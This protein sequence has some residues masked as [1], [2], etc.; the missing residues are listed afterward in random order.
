MLHT[1]SFRALQTLPIAASLPFTN[2][3]TEAQ[4]RDVT[5]SVSGVAMVRGTSDTDLV[6]ILNGKLCGLP[7]G[8]TTLQPNPGLAPLPN[9]PFQLQLLAEGL[10]ERL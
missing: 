9:T 2:Q 6:G 3:A 4:G 8:P 1:P 5:H 7:L 10:P